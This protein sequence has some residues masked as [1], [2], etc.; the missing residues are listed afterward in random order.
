VAERQGTT[1][2]LAASVAVAST[3]AAAQNTQAAAQVRAGGRDQAC[4]AF[5][6]RMGPRI[7]CRRHP[8]VWGGAGCKMVINARVPPTDVQASLLLLMC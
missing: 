5:G 6:A 1:N 7:G 8:W 4:V 3:D 2:S